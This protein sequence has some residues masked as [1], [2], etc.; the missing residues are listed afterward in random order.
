MGLDPRKRKDNDIYPFGSD[1][2]LP[3]G[4]SGKWPRQA[5]KIPVPHM[6]GDRHVHRSAMRS[7]VKRHAGKANALMSE[8][9][10]V[11]IVM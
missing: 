8:R 10:N 5:T 3:R 7:F 11:L 9:M 6:L 4:G 2:A 1:R